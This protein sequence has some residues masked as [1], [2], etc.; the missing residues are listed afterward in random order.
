MS[1]TGRTFRN[2]IYYRVMLL[3]NERL[4]QFLYNRVPSFRAWWGAR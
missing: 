3:G 1:G 2:R 4:T